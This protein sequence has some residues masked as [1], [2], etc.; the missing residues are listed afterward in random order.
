MRRLLVPVDMSDN[1]MRALRHAI[2]LARQHGP[3]DLVIVHAHDPP[4]IYGEASLY[5]SDE[6]ARELQKQ[7]SEDILRP[8]IEMAKTA[9]VSFTSEILIGNVPQEIVRCAMEKGCDGIVMGTRGKGA[10]GSLLMGSIAQKVV[11]LAEVPV[12]L[13]K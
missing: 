1:A 5:L 6:R 12:T 4:E 8:A 3:I 2:E 11:H 13:V 7:H 10:L 9:G